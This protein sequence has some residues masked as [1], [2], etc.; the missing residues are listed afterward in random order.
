MN[1]FS[2]WCVAK[3]VSGSDTYVRNQHLTRRIMVNTSIWFP[4]LTGDKH[5]LESVQRRFIGVPFGSVRP[6][7][8]DRL[9]LF[10]LEKFVNL[11]KRGD[12]IVTY[13]IFRMRPLWPVLVEHL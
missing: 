9:H 10:C 4:T 13:L 3:K 7:Y 2:P 6:S 11:R 8:E 12:L 1:T 5:L